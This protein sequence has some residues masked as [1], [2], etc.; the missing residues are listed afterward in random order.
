MIGITSLT[1][2]IEEA[3][4]KD[5]LLVIEREANPYLEV[6]A[7]AR[8]TDVGPVILFKNISGHPNQQIVT[9]IFSSRERVAY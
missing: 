9:N 8:A 4:K 1:K 3:K 7:V 5:D 6:A 2:L